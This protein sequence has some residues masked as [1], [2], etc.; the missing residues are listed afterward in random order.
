MTV[1]KRVPISHEDSEVDDILHPDSDSDSVQDDDISSQHPIKPFY[2]PGSWLSQLLSVPQQLIFALA[3][4]MGIANFARQIVKIKPRQAGA[5][6][7]KKGDQETRTSV[8]EWIDTNV[9][10]LKGSFTPSWWLPKYATLSMYSQ[11]SSLSGH[12]QT[13]FSVMGNF[14]VVDK[15][16]YSRYALRCLDMTM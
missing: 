13:I 14:N 6:K 4:L 3:G 8:N 11:S 2:L 7:V 1:R 5:V 15:V 16:D 12:L 9:P 10:S